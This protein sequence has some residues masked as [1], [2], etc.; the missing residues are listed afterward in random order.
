MCNL[1]ISF[2][3]ISGTV[4]DNGGSHHLSIVRG[5]QVERI[6]L[7]VA[8]IIGI[9]VALL[10]VRASFGSEGKPAVR[11]LSASATPE[12]VVSRYLEALKAG[13]PS[14]AET[15]ATKHFKEM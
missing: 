8:A 13:D 10:G 4:E 2:T 6:V 3:G 15:L 5:I 9:S 1:P 7:T 14:T 12:Q 11:A